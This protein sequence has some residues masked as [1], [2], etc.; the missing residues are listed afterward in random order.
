MPNG[1]VRDDGGAN[2]DRKAEH[3][4]EGTLDLARLRRELPPERTPEL[5]VLV[6]H[7]IRE[8]EGPVELEALARRELRPLRVNLQV[9]FVV[10][11]LS[12][13]SAVIPR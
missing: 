4:P 6:R 8:D 7:D 11:L 13:F 2:G 3:V 5:R 1:L 12:L 10:S 9:Q